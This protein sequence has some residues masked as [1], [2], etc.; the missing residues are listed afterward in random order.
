MTEQLLLA[1]SSLA[2]LRESVLFLGDEDVVECRHGGNILEAVNGIVGIDFGGWDVT[3]ND[4]GKNSAFVGILWGLD[5]VAG[6]GQNFSAHDV[7]VKVVYALAAVDA[8]VD[9]DAEA[10]R[11]LFLAELARDL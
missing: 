9:E 4:L 8:V 11:A 6:V 10:I 7:Q 1:V 5:Q 3:S 2:Q